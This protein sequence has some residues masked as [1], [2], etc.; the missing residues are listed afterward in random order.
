MNNC[1]VCLFARPSFI[2][3]EGKVIAALSSELCGPSILK[4]Q[5]PV[6]LCAR[7][8]WCNNTG[9]NMALCLQM[10]MMRDEEVGMVI[11]V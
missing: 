1:S 10:K 2:S 8:I 4:Q 3:I 11:W 7:S 9:Q 6:C 5:K